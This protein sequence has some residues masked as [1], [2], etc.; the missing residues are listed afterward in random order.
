MWA[1]PTYHLEELQGFYIEIVAHYFQKSFSEG[2]VPYQWKLAN[3]TPVH[4]KSSREQ[5]SLPNLYYI[6]DIRE[7]IN[8]SNALIFG[9]KQTYLDRATWLRFVQSM[10][11]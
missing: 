10:C 3:V 4:K 6:L 7:H 5:T 8:E 1:R 2:I 11:N 9:V